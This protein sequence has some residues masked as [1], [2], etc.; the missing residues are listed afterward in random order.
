[1]KFATIKTILSL[2]L[3]GLVLS[4]S[5]V[6]K[7]KT[8]TKTKRDGSGDWASGYSCPGVYIDNVEQKGGEA[9]ILA[10]QIKSKTDLGLTLTFTT[11]PAADSLTAKILTKVSDKVYFIPYRFI[12]A[13]T[14]A[15]N[16]PVGSNKNLQFS[17]FDDANVTHNFKINLPYKIFGWYISDEEANKLLGFIKTNS[18]TAKGNIAASKNKIGAESEN[19]I[20]TSALLA[21]ANESKAAL[22]AEVTRQSN[23]LAALEA[24][25]AD[26]AKNII[27]ARAVYAQKQAALQAAVAKLQRANQEVA[28][29]N[30]NINNIQAANLKL[31]SS[32]TPASQLA[33]SKK[34]FDE[35]EALMKDEYAKLAQE[36]T[37]AFATDLTNSEKGLK[38]GNKESFSAGLRTSFP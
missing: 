10:S 5:E 16:N 11:A 12:S 14:M 30:T 28:A 7:S 24:K 26:N 33:E 20:S 35:F 8:V 2:I 25:L 36:L 23:T 31:K 1:M 29:V 15:Y 17:F 6:R 3:I 32:D 27:A 21:K 38:D 18:L 34:K 19:F 4:N 37:P 13:D 9:K 22:D